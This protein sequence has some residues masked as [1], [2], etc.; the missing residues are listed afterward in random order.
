MSPELTAAMLR[1][2]QVWEGLCSWN[3]LGSSPVTP[4]AVRN[5]LAF[6]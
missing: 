4:E 5:D 1:T 2:G 6:W 3:A